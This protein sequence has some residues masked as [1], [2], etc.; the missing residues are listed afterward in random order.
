VPPGDER[1][2][3]MA[4]DLAHDLPPL[5]AAEREKLLGSTKGLRPLMKA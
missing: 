4:L 1:L 5:T 2:F 3:R